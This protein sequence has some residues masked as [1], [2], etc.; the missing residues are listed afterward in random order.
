MVVGVSVKNDERVCNPQ[1]GFSTNFVPNLWEIKKS[2]LWA[3]VSS[4]PSQCLNTFHLQHTYDS[5]LRKKT[6][7]SQWLFCGSYRNLFLYSFFQADVWMWLHSPFFCV[8][9]QPSISCFSWQLSLSPPKRTSIEIAGLT[10]GLW[11]PLV[12]LN[13]TGIIRG[14]TFS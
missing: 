1:W 9:F 12:S 7:F 13:T 3:K 5:L 4:A 11:K 6:Y 14:R 8:F 10:K 2:A